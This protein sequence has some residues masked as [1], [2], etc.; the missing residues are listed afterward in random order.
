MFSDVNLNMGQFLNESVGQIPTFCGIKYT[1]NDLDGGAA[2]L[3][4]NNGKYAV[5]LGAD[6]IMAGA[7]AM[8]F[9]SAIATTLNIYPQYAVNILKAISESKVEE[10]AKVQEQL[11]A[12][13]SIITKNGAWVP[14]MKVAMN[15]VSPI[16]VGVVRPPFENL[17]TE[18]SGEMEKSLKIH[19]CVYIPYGGHTL[20]ISPSD[21]CF[22]V[23]NKVLSTARV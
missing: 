6:T 19:F 4:A 21:V 7:F 9:D 23:S 16:N 2:A 10:A 20:E 3:R 12:V 8:G 17:S 18:H 22:G 5:F 15:L 13:V 11:S 14:T 1:S